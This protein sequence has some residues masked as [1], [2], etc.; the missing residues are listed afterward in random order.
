ML[1]KVS[2]TCRSSEVTWLTHLDLTGTAPEPVST[3][4][5][6]T[7]HDLPLTTPYYSAT[8]PVWLDLIASPS[9]WASSFLSEEAQ[10]VLAVLGGLVLVFSVQGDLERTRQLVHQVGRVVKE[11]LGGWEWDGVGLAVGVGEGQTEEWDELC[12]EAGLEFVQVTGKDK[13]RNEF[14]GKLPYHILGTAC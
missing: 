1:S 13:G 4:L 8:V 7:T 5:A 11:G 12:A 10:E 6:G 9:E 2:S 14:G 3:S